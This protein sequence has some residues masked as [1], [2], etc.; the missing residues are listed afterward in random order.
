LNYEGLKK[1]ETYNEII[2]YLMNKQEKIKTPNRLAKQLRESPQ[3]SN[4]L[5]GD[6]EGVLDMEQQQR[7]VAVEIERERLIRERAD[8]D[9]GAAERRA[10]EPRQQ[11]RQ[12]PE[13]FDIAVD[14][15]DDLENDID[16]AS[17]LARR[18]EEDKAFKMNEN[19]VDH[20]AKQVNQYKWAPKSPGV[21][22]KPGEA[23]SSAPPAPP[24]APPPPKKAGFTPG[25]PP[26]SDA[27]ARMAPPPK[28]LMGSVP[29]F[30]TPAKPRMHVMA[31]PTAPAPPPPKAKAKAKA[32]NIGKATQLS[33]EEKA[34][35]LRIRRVE[36]TRKNNAEKMKETLKKEE[37][38]KE[39][40]KNNIK[41]T[42]N[43]Q[44]ATVTR[45]VRR[46]N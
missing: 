34:E 35:R 22:Y 25:A 4:L 40:A 9:G 44:R 29:K 1:R 45:S 38:M 20:L 18:Q 16:M 37:R 32:F 3:L 33:P 41:E 17:E 2:D 15:D 19:L 6:G 27:R 14:S 13:W 39:E 23:A 5:D 8:E 11:P 7:R 43:N 10:F 24:P 42:Q 31:E 12:R 28:S 30:P 21:W 46:R 26:P 36:R